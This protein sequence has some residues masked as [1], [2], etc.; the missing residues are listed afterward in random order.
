MKIFLLSKINIW[1]VL[2]CLLFLFTRFYQITE[3]PKSLYWD[4]ASIGYNA[5][6]ILKTGHDEWGTRTPIHFR[7]FGEFKLPVYIYSTVLTESIFDLTPLGI[8]LPAVLYTLGSL[9]LIY[10]LVKKITQ[11]ELPALLSAFVFA[12]S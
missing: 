11:E 2:T 6:S 10:F 8:R 7:A 1:L 12:V 3:I 9:L 5:Y 4:E